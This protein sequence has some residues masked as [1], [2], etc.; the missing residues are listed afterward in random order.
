MAA[1]PMCEYDPVAPI[2][3][4]WLLEADSYCPTQNSL[5]G[6][7][8]AGY[9]YRRWRRVWEDTFGDQLRALPRSIVRRRVTITRFYGKGRRAYDR[10][11]F[12]GGCKPLI[13]TL[14]NMGA[15]YNDNAVFLEDHYQQVKSPDG[16]DRIRL[17][18]EDL[19]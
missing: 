9:D 14:V 13:D 19:A 15:L 5:K 16:V 11:N 10:G 18:I 7:T 2:G 3:E 12:I 8:K 4:T 1:C 6:N 17:L